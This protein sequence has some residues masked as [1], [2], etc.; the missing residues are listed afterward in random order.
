MQSSNV[1]DGSRM[2]PT[3]LTVANGNIEVV[4]RS[5][6]ET[7]VLFFIRDGGPVINFCFP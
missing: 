3:F 1:S 5:V 4:S 2:I 6:L 7:S